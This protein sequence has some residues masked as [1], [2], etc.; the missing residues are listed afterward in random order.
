M[1]NGMQR[2]SLPLAT[3]IAMGVCSL[4][5]PAIAACSD[6][7]APEVYWRRCVFDRQDLADVD[8]TGASLRDSSFK[9]ADLTASILQDVDARRA[10]FV[11]SIMQEVVLD[12]ANLVRADLTKADLKG[13]SLK[14]TDLTSARMFRADLSGADLTNARLDDADLLQAVLDGATWVDG[15]T[16]CAE[17]SVGRCRRSRAAVTPAPAP[18][19][20]EAKPEPPA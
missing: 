7:P 5:P 16:I 14:G 12:D 8:L 11:S 15:K 13:A 9:R 18:E 4:A 6:V 19:I 17:G 2:L 20:S 3:I 10:K 1:T